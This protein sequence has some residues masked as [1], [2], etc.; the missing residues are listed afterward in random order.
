MNASHLPALLIALAA[1][2]SMHA[3]TTTT[4]TRGQLLYDTHCVACHTQQIHWRD[5]GVVRNWNELRAQVTRWQAAARL[6]WTEDDIGQ[7]TRYLNAT[8]YRLPQTGGIVKRE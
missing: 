2:T 1:S 7:V 3:Q 8:I 5:A 6:G 4:P